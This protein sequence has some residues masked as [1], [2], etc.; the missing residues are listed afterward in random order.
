M[1]KKLLLSLLVLVAT[2]LQ[3]KAQV[4]PPCGNPPPPG[5]NSCTTT[6]V[7]CD[8]DGYMGIN[9]GPPSGGNVVC[10]Q[11]SIHNDQWFGFVAGSTTISIDILTSNC[12]NGDGLQVAFFAN[13]QDDAIVCNPGGQGQGGQPLNLTYNN[14]VPGQTYYLMIDGWVADV[15]NYEIDVIDGSV[16]APPPATPPVPQGPTIVC[17]GATAVYTIPDVDGAGYYVWTAPAGSSINGGGASANIP[18]PDGTTVTVTFGNGTGAVCVRAGNACN[19]ISPQSCK[20]ITNQPIPP[21]ILPK[22]IVCNEDLPFELPWGPQVNTSGTY[23]TTLD[24]YLGCDSVVKLPVV[25]IPPKFTNLPIINLCKGSTT[26]ICGQIYEDQ[27][28]YSITCT[29]F[30]GCDSVVN[31]AINVLD[32]IAD[33]LGG[34]TITC[35]NTSLTLNS[36][37]SAGTKIWKNLTLNTIAGTGNTLVVTQPGTYSLTT[38]INQ[39]G[40]TCAKSDTIVITGNTTPPVVTAIGGTIGCTSTTVTLSATTN[41]SMP[42]YQWSG[43]GGFTSTLSN[44]I[45]SITGT[46]ALTLTNSADGC[47]NTSTATVNANNTPPSASATGNTITCASPSVI[48]SASSNVGNATFSWT[49]PNGFTSTLANPSVNASGNYNVVVTNPTNSCTSTASASVTTNTSAPGATAS[50][51]GVISCPTPNVTLNGNSPTGS[52]TYSWAGPNSYTATGQTPSASLAGTYTVTV[53]GTVNG[54]T[55]T[56][57]TIVNG[58]TTAPTATAIG[59]TVTCGTPNI[60]LSSSTNA[61]NPTFSW[62]GPN[63]YAANT[64]NPQASDPGNYTVTI[65]GSN[66]C[67]N[68][69]NATVIGDFATPNASATGGI[70]TCAASSISIS[71]SSTTPN[72][73]FLWSGPG[74]FT[75]NLPVVNVNTVGTYTLTAIALNGCTATATA[76]VSPDAGIPNATATGGTL[77]CVTNSVTLNG[78]SITPN[79]SIGW[80]GPNG[81]SS[82]A[83]TPTVS[84]PGNYILTVTN[85]ANNCTAQASAFVALDTITPGAGIVGDTLTCSKPSITLQGS[86]VATGVSWSWTGPAG[87]TPST[88]QNPSTTIPGG[89]S[90]VVTAPNGCTSQIAKTIIANQTAPVATPTTGTLTCTKLSLD[91]GV[92][93]TLPVTYNWAGPLGFNASIA[94]P[95]VAIPGDYT[96]TVTA[97][98]GC[99]DAKTVTV[100]Q[101]IAAPGATATGDTISCSKPQVSVK[102]STPANNP[103]IVWGGPNGFV[104]AS[105]TALV[106]SNGFYSVTVT[107]ANGC[108]SIADATVGIDTVTAQ[109]QASP[110]DVLTCATTNV[111]INANVFGLSPISALAWTG[112]GGFTSAVEDPSVTQAGAYKLVATTANG[113]T[114]ST[115]AVVTQDITTP[116][117]SGTGGTLN[118]AITSISLDGMSPTAGSDYSWIGPSGFTS[119]LEDPTITASGTYTVIVTGPNGCTSTASVVVTADLTKPGATVTSSNNLNCID[120]SSNLLVTTSGA[121][122][123]FVWSGPGGFNSAVDNPT[124][125]IPGAYAVTVTG[126]NGC[127]STGNVTITQDITPPDVSAVTDTLTCSQPTGKLIGKSNTPNLIWSWSGPNSYKSNSQSPSNIVDDGTYDLLVT[128]ANGCTNTSS[129]VVLLDKALP[130]G[131]V[132]GGGTIS[133]DVVFADL[134]AVINTAGASGVWTLPNGTT[135]NNLNITADVGG[136]YVYKIT[137]TNGCVSTYTITVFENLITPADVTATGGQVNCNNPTL[138][139]KGNSS[140]PSVTYAWSGPNGFTSSD[141]NPVNISTGGQYT[142]VVTDPSNGCTTTATANVSVNQL[143]P[144]VTVVTDT[145]TCLKPKVVLNAT[146]TPANVTYSWTGPNGFTATIQDPSNISTPGNYTLVAKAVSS[147]CTASFTIPVIENTTKPEATAKGDTITCASNSGVL[148]ANSTTSNVTYLWT[149][150]GTF[151]SSQQNPTVTAVGTYTVVVTAKN[152]CT[153]SISV[154]VAPDKNA[155]QITATGG[156]K[157]CKSPSVDLNA[158]SNIAVTWTWTGPGGFTSNLPNPVATVA[159][160]YTVIATAANGCSVNTAVEV[161]D[162]TKGP[163]TA[164]PVIQKLTCTTTQI[165]LQV[166]IQGS[167]TYAYAWE[168]GNILS[169]SNTNTVIVTQA[170]TYTVTV[171][172]NVNGCTA[173]NEATVEADD[174]TPN[175]ATIS[176]RDI[177]CY[178]QSNGAISVAGVQG[179]LPPYLYSLDNA[180]FS[181]NASFSNLPPGDH[182]LVIQ[183]A[184]GCEYQ[185]VI[186]ITEPD[187]LLVNLGPDTIIHLGQTINLSIS[188][189]TNDPNR[190]EYLQVSPSSLFPGGVDSAVTLTP[191]YTLRYTVTAVDSNGCKASD[192]RLVI[193]DKKRLVYIPNV[194]NPDSDNNNLFMIFGVEPYDVEKIKVFQV[195]DRWG[196]V[197]HEY[198]NFLPNDPASGWDGR[199]RGDKATPAVFTYFAEILFK[200]GLTE[201]FKG[202]VLLER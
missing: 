160:N 41:A 77:D 5:A 31:F 34:G 186:P 59:D 127:T 91:L 6:C 94:N 18:A 182:E 90:L 192:S 147:G 83:N 68:T 22:Q 154:E 92:S 143:T 70:I 55:S 112:P 201:I 35:A 197:V 123:Q 74:G 1:G 106:S 86:A 50:V 89:Y 184:N 82:I 137:G 108:T 191:L 118:C 188:D 71:G 198:R 2:Y 199:I 124:A 27:G 138:T 126:A 95:T 13:C 15:C 117:A 171:T 187:S 97:A 58:N 178:G 87:F 75:S 150:P 162:D 54:C 109:L 40:A 164:V 176:A 100:L 139:L 136:N 104:S 196:G 149:G 11:I 23:S 134:S 3:M 102:V 37:N 195:F 142:L 33:I 44:P 88:L 113:C 172:N 155:P 10:G 144:T 157:T 121:Q 12:Q 158:S 194:F 145:I 38:T 140:T 67:T 45:V 8:F 26:T 21:T 98:N 43:P 128:A 183:D 51:T 148:T 64:Q 39:G 107:G 30:Q 193:V 151:S 179:G 181:G 25:V 168:G 56:A 76:V 42:T 62:S 17:P 72:V 167:G 177:V 129:A 84:T 103:I 36:A 114:S 141:Q 101:D 69:A 189:V 93:A 96:V 32:P 24:S 152:G 29:S 159:G 4:T 105:A 85:L 185:T 47:S 49:G 173:T 120:L 65:T 111:V 7:Y 133:C 115:T 73:A 190:I 146:V 79:V 163:Q 99:T 9:N 48:I 28:N 63:S 119:I 135:D 169:G 46:Y 122:P 78:N 57:T 202:D 161:I 174:D 20:P 180:P 52:V 166:E 170:A 53:T 19:P 66:G 131:A 175:A 80:T 153:N 116:G 61:S 125:S 200:D 132:S 60:N 16:T 130:D 81:F 110:A 156:T 165:T 14:F